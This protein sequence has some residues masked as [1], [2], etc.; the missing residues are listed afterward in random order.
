MSIPK[1]VY[2]TLESAP[3]FE[4]HRVGPGFTPG[5]VYEVLDPEP[6]TKSG[7]PWLFHPIDDDGQ[8]RYC[9]YPTSP[10]IAGGRWLD[11]DALQNQYP[12]TKRRKLNLA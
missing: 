6:P 12:R 5:K 1:R 2:F 11:A 4:Q 3:L 9:S 7:G 8:K 10:H